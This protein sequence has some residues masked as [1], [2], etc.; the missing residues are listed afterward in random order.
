MKL[1]LCFV[2]L[3]FVINANAQSVGIGTN[4][5]NP[6]AILHLDLGA[7]IS[8]GFL[9]TGQFSGSSTVPNL[10]AGSRLMFYPGKAAFRAG[11]VTGDLWDNLKVGPYSFAGGYN[12]TASNISS[13]AIGYSCTSTGGGSVAIGDFSQAIGENTVALGYFNRANADYST[14]LGFETRA[15]GYASTAMAWQ[16]IA[17]GYAST[18]VGMFNDTVFLT[19]EQTVT[20]TTPLFVVGNGNTIDDRSNAMVVRKDGRVGIGTSFPAFSLDVKGRARIQSDGGVNSAGVWLTKG[21]NSGLA[22]FVGM[23]NDSYVGLYGG[24]GGWDFVMNTST[25]NVG[26][27]TTAP[28][29][30]LSVNGNIC[31]TGTIGACSDIRYKKNISPIRHALADVLTL[32]GIYYFWNQEKF[33]SKQFNDERQIGFSAQEIEKLFPEMVQTDA[34]GYKSVDYSRM[35][36]VLV[37][38]IKDL[39]NQIQELRR[40]VAKLKKKTGRP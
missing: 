36:P 21:D 19:D 35:T 11:N 37:E 1:S 6:N 23:F 34:D 18:V 20:T 4:T 12:C 24:V 9:V 33:P 2:F 32:H 14:A 16:T 10:G 28:A 26:I 40:E 31:Y 15:T 22:A 29:Q 5:P 7:S 39:Q 13:V 27:G 8:N 30:K 25:G 17:K 38:A 3:S